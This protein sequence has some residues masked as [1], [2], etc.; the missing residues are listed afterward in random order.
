MLLQLYRNMNF[1]K[2]IETTCS[3]DPN[4]NN[5]LCDYDA[6]DGKVVPRPQF[7]SKSLT[8]AY[9]IHKIRSNS[10]RQHYDLLK[11]HNVPETPRNNT[12]A[13]HLNKES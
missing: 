1:K 4:I 13:A 2:F 10:W 5:S 3:M 8:D 12:H 11:L 9:P 6:A 7:M